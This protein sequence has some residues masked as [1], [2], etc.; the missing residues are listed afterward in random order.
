[1]RPAGVRM[2]C[3]VLMLA[4]V[5]GWGSVDCRR[6]RQVALHELRERFCELAQFL[7][8]RN[9]SGDGLNVAPEFAHI[10]KR[11][12]RGG[13]AHCSFKRSVWGVRNRLAGQRIFGNGE[14]P[15]ALNI[16]R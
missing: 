11:G 7:V 16:L 10:V 13:S 14:P 4:V 12:R 3:L 9:G 6:L 5:W 1:M 8:L 2:V 15:S